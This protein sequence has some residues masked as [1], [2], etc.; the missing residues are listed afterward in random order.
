MNGGSSNTPFIISSEV[1]VSCVLVLIQP[2]PW[3]KNLTPEPST[4]D[5]MIK[6]VGILIISSNM[7]AVIDLD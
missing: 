1:D 2:A 7:E 3:S 5:P 4:S 6:G